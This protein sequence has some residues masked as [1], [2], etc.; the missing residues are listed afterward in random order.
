MFFRYNTDPARLL[1]VFKRFRNQALRLRRF[2]SACGRLLLAACGIY[3]LASFV[4]LPSFHG[5]A[6]LF[7]PLAGTGAAFL[8][9][10]WGLAANLGRY[11][12]RRYSPGGRGGS[13]F[14]LVVL[15]VAVIQVLTGLWDESSYAPMFDPTSLPYVLGVWAWAGLGAFLLSR[16]IVWLRL[17]N[18]H[19]ED[20]EMDYLDGVLRA[21]LRDLP[22][23][24]SCSLV[25]NPFPTAWTM[26]FTETKRGSHI[27]HTYDD[28]L[29][30]FKVK[31][32][33]DTVL[34][35]RT[36]HRRIDKFKQAR[37]KLKDKGSKHRVVQSYRLEH[38]ALARMSAADADRFGKLASRWQPQAGGYET[39]LRR[40]PAS[41]RLVVVQ[42]KKFAAPRDLAA[43]DL[44][45]P[46]LVLATVRE[47]SAFAASVAGKTA[48]PAS[49]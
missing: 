33:G 38:P 39:S 17:G 49:G 9:I 10:G 16:W 22:S 7:L 13:V 34:T 12:R 46:A 40:D 44:P 42:K 11:P 20:F 3:G 2:R 48:A 1:H 47:L 8:L 29:L 32:E 14:G 30:E 28:A 36:L 45:S 27:F 5:F 23:G 6:D 35:L 18:V 37:K 4:L 41:G 19:V 43:G 25:C 21:L 15:G 24:A 31:V 26:N